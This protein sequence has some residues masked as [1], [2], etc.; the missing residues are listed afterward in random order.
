MNSEYFNKL[1]SD[2][3]EN[4]FDDGI[5]VT[6]FNTMLM[7]IGVSAISMSACCSVYVASD[8]EK[9]DYLKACHALAFAH[10]LEIVYES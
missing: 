10:G 1:M 4:L 7:L 3:F 6:S 5:H 2:T 8:W 9:D